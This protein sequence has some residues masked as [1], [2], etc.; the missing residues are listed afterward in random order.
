M[1]VFQQEEIQDCLNML[2]RAENPLEAVSA[3]GKLDKKH[4]DLSAIIALP[5]YKSSFVPT[6]VK[7]HTMKRHEYSVPY[8]SSEQL[9]FLDN[10]LLSTMFTSGRGKFEIDH[11][12][13]FDSN[14]AT[15]INNLVR[16]ESLGTVHNK[17]I[18]FIDS[19]LHDD[20][21]FDY[22]FYM[23]ENIK[24]VYRHITDSNL[25]KLNLWRLLNKE[26]RQNMVALKIFGSI[27]CKEYKK[28]CNPKPRLSYLQ[29]AREAVNSCH[30]FYGT[31]TSQKK[32]SSILLLQ[33]V[34]LLKL[35][36]IVRIQ[37]SSSKNAKNKM[38]EYFKFIEDVAGVYCDREAIIA[39]KY[40]SDRSSINFFGK[41]HKGCRKIR[42]LKRLDNLAWDMVVPRL[43]E[44][45]MIS[46]SNK[47]R[48]F[49]PA[50]LTSDV[51]LRELLNLYPVKGIVF[52]REKR[53]FTPLP[54]INTYEYF[55]QHGCSDEIEYLH[56]EQTK[57]ERLQKRPT[58][59]NIHTL[60]RHEYK[61][62]RSLI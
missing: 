2:S 24:K 14:I 16:G 31:D 21:N 56:N 54:E 27:D 62:F 9:Y 8:F 39:H 7:K 33:K 61:S 51:K 60:I 57:F 47:N 46:L 58:Q 18:M 53:W 32:V 40:F 35:I 50:F 42:L 20:L 23:V 19:I 17:F 4:E 10:E 55:K 13:M 52:H 3:W 38:R 26:F 48:Y 25:S 28:T 11:T 30:I 15:Y 49:V 44:D 29:A 41:V 5:N 6:A 36:G 12:L 22:T 43:M 34:L 45:L 37:L 59:A 1:E